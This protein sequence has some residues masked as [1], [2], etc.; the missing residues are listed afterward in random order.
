MTDENEMKAVDPF[1]ADYKIY[2][3]GENLCLE[4]GTKREFY[5]ITNRSKIFEEFKQDTTNWLIAASGSYNAGDISDLFEPEDDALYILSLGVESDRN[6][7]FEI[8]TPASDQIGGIK[9]VASVSIVPDKSSRNTPTITL[10][11]Y[12]TSLIPNFKLKNNTEYTPMMVKLFYKGFKYKLQKLP[13]PPQVFDTVS[14][15]SVKVGA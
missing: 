6:I 14:L 9:N 3:I 10:N 2:R 8:Y 7:E 5:K 4:I 12:G 15:I 11:S 1:P 13:G